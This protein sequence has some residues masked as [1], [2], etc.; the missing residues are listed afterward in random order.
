MGHARFRV[1]IHQI[2]S[3]HVLPR[4]LDILLTPHLKDFSI[5]YLS[6]SYGLNDLPKAI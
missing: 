6:L 4:Y 5:Y 1:R 2:R 3:S